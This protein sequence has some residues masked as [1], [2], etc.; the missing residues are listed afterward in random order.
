MAN[1]ESPVQRALRE[2][3]EARGNGTNDNTPEPTVVVADSATLR[4]TSKSGI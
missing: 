4:E 2:A 1:N 3:R